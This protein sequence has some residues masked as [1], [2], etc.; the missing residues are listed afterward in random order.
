[1]L[2]FWFNQLLLYWNISFNP[3]ILL[4]KRLK[5]EWQYQCRPIFIILEN[6]YL[7]NN[8]M[9]WIKSFVYDFVWKCL[10]PLNLSSIKY[11]VLLSLLILSFRLKNIY[12][13]DFFVLFMI[14]NR[15]FYSIIHQNVFN[16]YSTWCEY[17]HLTNIKWFLTMLFLPLSVFSLLFS[18]NSLNN[19]TSHTLRRCNQ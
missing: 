7:S 14:C 5:T 1:M 17:S 16:V 18:N 10:Y 4:T 11:S 13:I 3:S 6:A 9:F 8:E 2:S 19:R 15:T 12:L